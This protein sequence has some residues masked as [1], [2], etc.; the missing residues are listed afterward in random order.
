MPRRRRVGLGGQERFYDGRRS[1]TAVATPKGRLGAARHA[2]RAPA[3]PCGSRSISNAKPKLGSHAHRRRARYGR[4]TPAADAY[5]SHQR[6]SNQQPQR[7]HPPENQNTDSMSKYTASDGK[8]FDTKREWR[9][10]EML[11]MY[12]F[13][14]RPT[15]PS[16]SK[17]RA[18]LMGN[19]LT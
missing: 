12:T 10:Y 9:K 14:R 16:P 15:T 18:T 3:E 8:E 7:P 2:S 6:A 13:K 17:S 5:H 1:A 11:L 4:T 19:N